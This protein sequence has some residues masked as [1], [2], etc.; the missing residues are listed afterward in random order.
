MTLRISQGIHTG[1]S[2]TFAVGSTHVECLTTGP[3]WTRLVAMEQ[4]AAADEIL[5]SESTAAALP[6]GATTS[7]HAR[8]V[9]VETMPGVAERLLR[10]R[11]PGASVA[12][13]TRVP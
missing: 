1:R 11:R 3:A 2:D 5:A 10:C 6:D 8:G 4:A 7:A 13:A 12:W 9:L